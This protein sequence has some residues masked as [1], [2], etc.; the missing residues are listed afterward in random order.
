VLSFIPNMAVNDLREI[1]LDRRMPEQIRK[2][3]LAHCT[4]RLAK[5]PAEKSSSD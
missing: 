2:Y 3:I 5:K 4:E 1:C